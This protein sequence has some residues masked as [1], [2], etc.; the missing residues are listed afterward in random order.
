MLPLSLSRVA[1]LSHAKLPVRSVTFAVLAAGLMAGPALAQTNSPP[2]AK[3]KAQTQ[4]QTETKAP[5]KSLQAASRIS[6]SP[7][8]SY[9]NETAR[10]ISAAMLS[11]STLEVRGGWPTLPAEV[12]KLAPGASGPEVAL[13]RERLAITDDLRAPARQRRR[14]RRQSHRRDPALPVAPRPR[15]DRHHR[16]AHACG[17]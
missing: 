4:A 12:M 7:H 9:D 14:V 15:R 1:H 6:N 17:A 8:P 16:A 5:K 3:A 11:Y 13:L 10:R 2:K